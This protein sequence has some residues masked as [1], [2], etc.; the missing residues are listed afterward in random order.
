MNLA[1]KTR[2]LASGKSQIMLAREIGISE[3]QL[4]KVVGGWVRPDPKVK[5]KIAEVLGC[6]V[7]DIFFDSSSPSTGGPSVGAQ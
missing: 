3:P 2:I 1:L 7:E 4:S 6:G 5:T